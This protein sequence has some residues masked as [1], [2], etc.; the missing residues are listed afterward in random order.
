MSLKCVKC[1]PSHFDII[2]MTEQWNVYAIIDT[3]LQ[4]Y[5]SQIL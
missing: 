2:I 3:I 4:V 5:K 1:V